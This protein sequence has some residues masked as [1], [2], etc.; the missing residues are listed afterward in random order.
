MDEAKNTW[1]IVLLAI[2]LYTDVKRGKIYNIATF[3]S[4]AFG[5]LVNGWC[6]GFDGIKWSV[7]G[8]GVSLGIFFF[9]YILGGLKA[10]DVKLLCAVGAIKGPVFAFFACMATAVTGGIIAALLLLK[11]RALM[12]EAKNMG[13]KVFHFVLYKIPLR[14]DDAKSSKF[15]YGVAITLGTLLVLLAEMLCF[16]PLRQ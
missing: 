1:V 4:M 12:R 16:L 10:G 13:E 7:L 15:P 5:M 14:L 9:P 11:R 2:A 3:P 8:W 6:C